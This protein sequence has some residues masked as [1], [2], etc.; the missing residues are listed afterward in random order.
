LQNAAERN[1]LLLHSLQLHPLHFSLRINIYINRKLVNSQ[2]ADQE[3]NL[4][5]KAKKNE[6]KSLH[7]YRLIFRAYQRFPTSV[8]IAIPRFDWASLNRL[9]HTQVIPDL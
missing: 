5:I 8:V 2:K 6:R 7:H 9:L 3:I 1:H 4:E